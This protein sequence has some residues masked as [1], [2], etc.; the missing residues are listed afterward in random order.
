MLWYLAAYAETVETFRNEIA[1]GTIMGSV[2]RDIS[3]HSGEIPPND[4]NSWP[5]H[6]QLNLYWHNQYFQTVL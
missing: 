6:Q 4:L 2:K 3:K 5:T 1:A